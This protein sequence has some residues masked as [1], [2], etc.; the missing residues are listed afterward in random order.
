MSKIGLIGS[1]G[2]MNYANLEV[3]QPEAKK[4]P[5]GDP[6]SLLTH[7]L[8][9]GKEVVL[10]QRNSDAGTIPPHR[11]N[12]R[13]NIWA[14]HEAGV[15]HIFAFAPVNSIRTD[16]TPGS[17]VLPDQLIDYTYGRP[18]TFFDD[19]F[20]GTRHIDFRFPY[21][22]LLR[23]LVIT[24]ANDMDLSITDEATYGVCQGPR[25][26][27]LAEVNR[28]ERDG[29]DVIGMS[30]M[31]ETI[32]ARELGIEYT[33]ICF[34]THKAAGRRASVTVAQDEIGNVLLNSLTGL[35]SLME[36][37]ILKLNG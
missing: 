4:T 9:Q 30:G 18:H 26:A 37:V 7:G 19:N 33:S 21:S 12:Y 8:L 13:A 10:L 29:C 22:E 28:L 5:Y 32:L 3:L 15:K 11:I 14:L 24:T 31:P 27:T 25:L 1:A 20:D 23:E 35:R 2:L 34:V 17:L 36:E 16:L 6:S